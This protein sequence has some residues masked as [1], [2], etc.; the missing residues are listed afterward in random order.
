MTGGYARRRSGRRL[1]TWTSWEVAGDRDEA[2]GTLRNTAGKQTFSRTVCTAS[3]SRQCPPSLPKCLKN[4]FYLGTSDRRVSSGLDGP[5][6]RGL[7]LL[8]LARRPP[9]R[10]ENDF[11]RG[12]ALRHYCRDHCRHSQARPTNNHGGSA[13]TS[14]PAVHGVGSAAQP[15]SYPPIEPT[16][17]TPSP[18]RCT[19]APTGKDK[20]CAE[21]HS[22][23]PPRQPLA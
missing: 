1:W 13:A 12:L 16:T 10:I 3:R 17:S 19:G 5:P 22:S 18:I 15:N 9:Y 11:S 21:G 2:S 7:T 8:T 14:T 20:T 6:R 4:A 23:A